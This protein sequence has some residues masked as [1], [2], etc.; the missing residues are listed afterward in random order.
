MRCKLSRHGDISHGVGCR[1][2]PLASSHWNSTRGRVVT[3]ASPDQSVGLAIRAP[4]NQAKC[5]KLLRLNH[6]STDSNGH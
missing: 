5:L 3:K 2:Q 4:V 1:M 6:L